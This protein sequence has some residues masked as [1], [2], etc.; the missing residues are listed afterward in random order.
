VFQSKIVLRVDFIQTLQ[1][2]LLFDDSLLDLLGESS[3]LYPAN[4]GSMVWLDS[5]LYLFP[6]LILI[7]YCEK[8]I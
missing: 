6:R 7:L 2:Y 8:D 4:D 5:S 1:F 3:A